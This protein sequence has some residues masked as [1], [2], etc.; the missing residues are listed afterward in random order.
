M[1]LFCAKALRIEMIGSMKNISCTLSADWHEAAIEKL[2]FLEVTLM[3][4][5]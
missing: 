1:C 5:S 3:L 2:P 4:T